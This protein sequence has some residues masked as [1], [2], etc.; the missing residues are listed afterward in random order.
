M[1]ELLDLL[2]ADPLTNNAILGI[3]ALAILGF[4][5]GTL[6]A[7]ADKSFVW[8]ALDV[9]IRKDL[10]GRVIPIILILAFGRVVGTIKVGDVELAVLTATGLIAAATYA[11]TAVTS[12]VAS[13]NKNAPNPVPTDSGDVAPDNRRR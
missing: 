1:K 2:V 5:L 13:L 10:M 4:V 3:V 9:W 6:R 7:V 8:S 12:I 11:A